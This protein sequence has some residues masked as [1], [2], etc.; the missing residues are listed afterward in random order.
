[1]YGYEIAQYK[2]FLLHA[3]LHVAWTHHIPTHLKLH[4]SRQYVEVCILAF[5]RLVYECELTAPH[6]SIILFMAFSRLN[7]L[8][9]ASLMFSNCSRWVSRFISTYLRRLE[10]W[11][12]RP[13]YI[14]PMYASLCVILYV[15]HGCCEFK[16]AAIILVSFP[17]LLDPLQV[18]HLPTYLLTPRKRERPGNE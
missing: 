8:L 13:T 2:T 5:S 1:M 9:A 18:S 4:V 7:S 10:S 14:Q 6:S 16:H 12:Y 17:G 11:E 15:V 3:A